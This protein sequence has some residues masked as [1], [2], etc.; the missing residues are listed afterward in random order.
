MTIPAGTADARYDAPDNEWTDKQ[1]DE[2]KA[3]VKT[4]LG[5]VVEDAIDNIGS[6]WEDVPELT[7]AQFEDARDEAIATL[8]TLKEKL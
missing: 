2:I 1:T 7:E 8:R 4:I 5:G 3:A 6:L